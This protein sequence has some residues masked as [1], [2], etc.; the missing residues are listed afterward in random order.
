M[1]KETEIKERKYDLRDTSIEFVLF[2]LFRQEYRWN[3]Y[4]AA[5]YLAKAE[6]ILQ[7]HSVQRRPK[8]EAGICWFPPLPPS[9]GQGRWQLGRSD[10][11][12]YILFL[13]FDHHDQERICCQINTFTGGVNW[14]LLEAGDGLPILRSTTDSG[15]AN[16]DTKRAE[17]EAR[18]FLEAVQNIFDRPSTLTTE[19]AQREPFS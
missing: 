9:D 15:R 8:D 5:K 1:S 19:V 6:K 18:L 11:N 2:A 12:P 3:A 10:N 14:G 13:A 16:E 17:N 7:K 4:W